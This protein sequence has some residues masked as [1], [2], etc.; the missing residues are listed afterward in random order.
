MTTANDTAAVNL[1]EQ[2]IYVHVFR[3]LEPYEFSA[4]ASNGELA[5][6]AIWADMTKEQQTA[7]ETGSTKETDS[8]LALTNRDPRMRPMMPSDFLKL[9]EK[10]KADPSSF[11]LHELK[12][13]PQHKDALR[14]VQERQEAAWEAE[15]EPVRA[16]ARELLVKRA[17]DLGVS[18]DA[19]AII[20]AM[21]QEFAKLH[22]CL[23]QI[24]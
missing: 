1:A 22:D 11:N 5:W 17:S 8:Y 23:D 9:M 14:K 24:K 3:G 16:K 12:E 15:L 7:H 13:Y 21:Q 10:W 19:M 6:A 4:A 18:V 20:E 2:N